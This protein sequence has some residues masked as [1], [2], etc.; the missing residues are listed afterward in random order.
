MIV[1]RDRQHALDIAQQIG[2]HEYLMV[3]LVQTQQHRGIED[4][5]PVMKRFGIVEIVDRRP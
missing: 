4:L 5:E 3:V 1:D 2:G